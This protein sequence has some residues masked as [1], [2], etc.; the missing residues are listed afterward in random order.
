MLFVVTGC[1]I[2]LAV[3]LVVTAIIGQLQ[4]M[5][6]PPHCLHFTVLSWFSFVF[7]QFLSSAPLS[8]LAL[9]SLL[10]AFYIDSLA[11]VA[12]LFLFLSLSLSSPFFGISI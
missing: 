10:T 6:L 11:I 8:N 9:F 2:M 7:Y 4:M 3:A 12:F 1:N 5:S